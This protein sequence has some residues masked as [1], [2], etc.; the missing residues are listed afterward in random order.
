MNQ[1]E[2]KTATGLSQNLAGALCY[3]AGWI[4]GIIFLVLEKDN[5]F[6]RFHAVQSIA[7]SVVIM[8]AYFVI[9]FI[10]VIGVFLAYILDAGTFILWIIMMFKAYQGEQYK[11]PLVGNFAEQQVK[12][13]TE[14]K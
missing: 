3:L 6:V 11:L 14:V 9:L 12:P 2:T 4:T 5:R 8:I 1:P 13:K 7:V 10:P